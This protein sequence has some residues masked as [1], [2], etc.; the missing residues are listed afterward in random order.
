VTRVPGQLVVRSPE[1]ERTRTASTGR[2][3]PAPHP[4]DER[5]RPPLWRRWVVAT[6][7]GETLGFAVPAAVGALAVGLGA[8]D[9]ATVPLALVA[10]AAEGAILAFA[11]SRVLRRELAGFETRDWIA[12]TAAAAALCWAIGMSLGVYGGSLP[13]AVLASGAIVAAL[14]MLTAVGGAQW[15]VLRRH[16]ARA[17][18]W[19]PANA[20]GWLLGLAVPFTGMAL[21]DE[22]DPAVL[23][24]LVGVASGLGM[25][26]VVAAVT[27]LALVRLLRPAPAGP[28]RQMRFL[29]RVVNPLVRLLLRSPLHPIASSS[30]I[31]LTYTGRRSGLARSLPV[32]YAR[33]DG[34]L[35]VVAGRPER[36]R[37]W[38]NLRSPAPVGIRLRGHEYEGR[39]RLVT[40]RPELERELA[41]Y[42]ARFPRAAAS[43]G[44]PLDADRHPA[45]PALSRAAATAVVVAIDLAGTRPARE[46]RA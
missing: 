46:G 27:G 38:R 40:A 1:R 41:L 23:G 2:V 43:L 45:A 42:L 35:V 13:H 19:I 6:T 11:Q 36:K 5:D 29:N 28:P 30:L 37:W 3:P 7:V 31:V 8:G 4:G 9:A 22:G 21:V 16:A 26:F 33:D 39:A 34:R 10:G 17:W 18:R 32:M 25:G 12:A 14:V 24:L 44:V 15:L 20:L